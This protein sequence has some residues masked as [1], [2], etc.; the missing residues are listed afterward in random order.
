MKHGCTPLFRPVRLFTLAAAL[1]LAGAHADEYSDVSQLVRAGK[2]AEAQA[3]VDRYLDAKPRDPQMRFIKGVIQRDSGRL[4]DAIITFTKLTE[5][6]PELPE[7]YNN[8]AVIYAGLSQFDKARSAL[9]MAIRT[10]PSYATAHQNL[11]DVYAKLASQAYN[12][13]LQIDS[14][15][16]A[17]QPKLALIRE[18]YNPAA[19]GQHAPP[20]STNA[21]TVQ[22]ALKPPAPGV[23][24]PPPKPPAP[25]PPAPAAAKPTVTATARPAASSIAAAVPPK[26]AATP[27]TAPTDGPAKDVQAAVHA[28]AKAWADRNMAGYLGAYGQ[29]FAPPGQLS[30]SAWEQE[31]RLRIT[32]KSR[33]SVSLLNLTVTVNG[34]RA[35]AKFHQDYKADGLAVLSRKTLELVKTGDRWMIVKE[36]SGA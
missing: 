25:T 33:I 12:K 18:L 36:T 26:A 32:G 14:S 11:G 2:L 19:A 30:R 35:V 21:P 20:P 17:E 24:V 9:E 22:A 10:N 6:H 8:L 13:A 29:E 4:A 5:D 28:W 3:R 34:N 16:T 15:N 31:R 23:A 7:P 27:P 1:C